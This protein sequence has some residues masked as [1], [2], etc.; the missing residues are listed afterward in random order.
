MAPVLD[1]V[2][3]TSFL[4]LLALTFS[5]FNSGLDLLGPVVK[6]T[7]K[8][9]DHLLVGG[10]SG[11]DVFSIVLPLFVKLL[12]TDV[13]LDAFKGVLEFISELFEHLGELSLLFFLAYS[14]VSWLE[15][16]DKGLEDL[17][18]DYIE[19]GNGVL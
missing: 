3:G 17:V 7:L 2:A 15:A 16:V 18:N 6:D 13:A 8:V 4:I 12:Q 10:L 14:P 9:G 5:L 1:L 19:G 11:L